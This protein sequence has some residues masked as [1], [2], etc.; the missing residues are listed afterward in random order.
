MR[1]LVRINAAA[2]I[3]AL[4]VNEREA[5]AWNVAVRMGQERLS[6]RRQPVPSLV[7]PLAASSKAHSK[8]AALRQKLEEAKRQSQSGATGEDSGI[9]SVS[10]LS[11]QDIRERNDRLR[12]EELLRKGGSVTALNDYSSDGYLNRQQEEEEIDAAST[13]LYA[14]CSSC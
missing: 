12:F 7:S 1:P 8:Q 5:F 9:P 6:R 11:D 4:A 14:V 3:V 2:V 10:S 13:Y